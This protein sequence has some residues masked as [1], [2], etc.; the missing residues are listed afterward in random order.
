MGACF[1]IYISPLASL[2]QLRTDKSNLITIKRYE[3][4]A[5]SGTGG[6]ITVNAP[7]LS[8]YTLLGHWFIGLSSSDASVITRAYCYSQNSP[9]N[10]VYI[11]WGA[12]SNVSNV[13]AITLA[14]FIKN[15]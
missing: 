10:G 5:F 13:K 11:V 6:S 7:T 2:T 8:G 12:A 15:D 9:T 4:S 14:L 3:S 1:I